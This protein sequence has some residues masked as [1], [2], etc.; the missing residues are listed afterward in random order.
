MKATLTAYYNRDPK[1]LV[2]SKPTGDWMEFD[3]FLKSLGFR[4]AR[5]NCHAVPGLFVFLSGSS[6]E[7]EKVIGIVKAG[8]E[9][10]TSGNFEFA[11]QV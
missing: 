2:V 8:G 10:L 7:I 9:Y 3:G 11:F 4:N 5:H 1:Q 6:D